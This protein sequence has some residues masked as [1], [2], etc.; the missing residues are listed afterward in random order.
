[1]PFMPVPGSEVF[2]SRIRTPEQVLASIPDSLPLHRATTEN[3][4]KIDAL[5][6]EV[7]RHRLWAITDLMGQALKQMSGSLVVTDCNDFDVSIT[8]ELGE[9]VQI[10]PYNTELAAAVDLAVKWVLQN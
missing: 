9:I 10:G 3:V 1:M 8:D 4:D 7:I 5:T 2:S 6:Y